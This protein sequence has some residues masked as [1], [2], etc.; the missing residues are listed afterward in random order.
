MQLNVVE[1]GGSKRKALKYRRDV[2]KLIKLT[3]LFA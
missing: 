2:Y 3:V 1:L